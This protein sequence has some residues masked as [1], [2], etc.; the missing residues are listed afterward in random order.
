MKN[1]L[2]LLA[3]SALVTSTTLSYASHSTESTASTWTGTTMSHEDAKDNGQDENVEHTGSWS[4]MQDGKGQHHGKQKGHKTGGER[5]GDRDHMESTGSQDE[6]EGERHGGRDHMESTGSQDETEST[7]M[8][9]HK[10]EGHGNHGGMN[11][12]SGSHETQGNGRY[13]AMFAKKIGTLL[14]GFTVEKLQTI[15]DRVAALNTKVTADTTMDGTKKAN[16]LAQISALSELI[17]QKIDE[18]NNGLDL[19]TLLQ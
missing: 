18:K 14:D 9:K 19:N 6:T 16:L 2:R 3:L 17:K 7:D 10:G 8:R 11:S 15:L 4:T 13:K 5:H 12:G 1:I